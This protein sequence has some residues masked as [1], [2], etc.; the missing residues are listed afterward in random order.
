MDKI[1]AKPMYKCAICGEVYDS[2]AQRLN[3]EQTCL[4]KQEEEAR[5]AAEAKK[6]AERNADFEEASSAIDNAWDLVN[7]CV[8]KYGTFKYNGKLTNS[9]EPLKVDFLPSKL[10]SY[11]MF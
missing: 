2:I 1:C 6:N 9:L 8:E 5:K 3:C 4:K 11:F 10:F 7:K